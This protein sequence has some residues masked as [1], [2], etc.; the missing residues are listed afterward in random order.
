ME[1]KIL[2]TEDGYKLGN[3]VATGLAPRE[4]Q[5][6]LL[7]ASGFSVDATAKAMNCGRSN[8]QDRIVNLFYKLHANSTTEL[9]TKAFQHGF[10]K[11]LTLVLAVQLSAASP[12]DNKFS[13][14]RTA[15]T[16][17]RRELKVV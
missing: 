3:L 2:R 9:V 5:A 8:V 17:V 4:S 1:T 6:L 7:R 15:R 10:L 14:T 16:T 12:D 11:F 13:R